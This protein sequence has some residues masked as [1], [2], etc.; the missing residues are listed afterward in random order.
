MELE[1][2]HRGTVGSVRVISLATAALALW[3]PEH[4]WDRDPQ[5]FLSSLELDIVREHN[6]VRADPTTYADFLEELEPH[7]D[8]DLFELPDGRVLRTS[9]GVKAVEEA[10][11]F[12]RDVEPLGSVRPSRGMSLGARDLLQDQGPTGETGHVGSDGSHPWDRV[13]RYGEWEGSVAENVAYGPGEAREVVMQL[14]ID[15]GVKDRGHRT[16]I[17]DPAFRV[18][19]VSCGEHARYEMMCVITYARGYTEAQS[20]D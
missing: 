7:F 16:N 19:G 8:G 13:S 6:L 10:I 14:I 4:F 2:Q 20:P 3:A 17:F 1:G 15:D 9:E 12:L 18:V 11:R 5:D